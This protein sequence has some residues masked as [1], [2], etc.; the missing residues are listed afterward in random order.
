MAATSG[1]TNSEKNNDQSSSSS[2]PSSPKQEASDNSLI[3]RWPSLTMFRSAAA[4]SP[5][6]SAGEDEEKR[7]DGESFTANSNAKEPSNENGGDPN[8]SSEFHTKFQR[9][10]PS[11]STFLTSYNGDDGASVADE[12]EED[13]KAADSAPPTKAEEQD[14]INTSAD[15]FQ[16]GW[17]S[18][19]N[20]LK[21]YRYKNTSDAPS[22]GDAQSAAQEYIAKSSEEN[23]IEEVINITPSEVSLYDSLR[24]MS[25]V[26]YLRCKL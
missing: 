12:K 24:T 14:N 18:I 8:S 3:A 19:K 20:F 7:A 1:E 5:P 15:T 23:M 16:K 22:D 10:W 17:P 4:V 11:I 26:K 13:S 21:S 9:A 2:S 25:R 6:P